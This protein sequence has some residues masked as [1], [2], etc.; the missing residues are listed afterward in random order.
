MRVIFLETPVDVLTLEETLE[1]INHAM[2][3][4]NPL[5]HVA[6]NVAKLVK[7]RA[8]S[9]L[10]QDVESADIIGIDGMGIVWG[11]RMLGTPVPERVAGFDLMGSVLKLCAERGYR[12][13]FLGA[14]VDIVRG[15]VEKTMQKYPDLVFAGVHHGYFTALEEPQILADIER[16]NADCLFIGM[17]T[18]AK[19]RFLA[20]NGAR[21]ATPFIMGVGG[22]FDVLSGYMKRAPRWARMWGLEWAYRIYQEPRRMWRRYATT[23]AQFLW[24]FSQALFKRMTS[25]KSPEG[26]KTAGQP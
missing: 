8:D 11:M 5:R 4:G 23:N 6:L 3:K 10:R 12:P 22:S 13:Y 24:L 25:R 16:S 20:R 1:S 9:D 19:E 14:K 15:A 26:S 7:M 21:L 17:P 18:P 2:A